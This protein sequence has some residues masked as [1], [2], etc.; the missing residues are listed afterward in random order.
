MLRTMDTGQ[1]CI[2]DKD[3]KLHVELLAYDNFGNPSLGSQ[4]VYDCTPCSMH[5]S[6]QPSD[7]LKSDQASRCFFSILTLQVMQ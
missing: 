7:G 4:V 5:G 1:E 3:T 2:L 6:D